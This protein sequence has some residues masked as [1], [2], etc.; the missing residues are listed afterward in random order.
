MATMSTV[1]WHNSHDH[2]N[3]PAAAATAAVRSAGIQQPEKSPIMPS[4]SGSTCPPSNFPDKFQDF[5]AV[6][7]EDVDDLPSML[8]DK[9][10]PR[11]GVYSGLESF[12]NNN[13][14]ISA[15]NNKQRWVKRAF[16]RRS[17]EVEVRLHAMAYSEN[18]NFSGA[19]GLEGPKLPA[20]S[21]RRSSSIAVARPTPD[22]HRF[23]QAEAGPWGHLSPSPRSPTRTPAFSPGATS[24][25]S[26][27][28]SPGTSSGGPSPTSPAAPSAASASTSRLPLQ[29]RQRGRTSSMP[30]V[31][32]HKIPWKM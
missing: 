22:L 8:E 19:G 31:P 14:N 1:S 24:T 23:L 17:S 4:S 20:P 13:N 7:N 25:T 15:S 28:L 29:P 6:L 12:G 18:P 10:I 2:S 16:Q 32:R 27:H 9:L 5:F 26:Q 11:K 3:A 21:R 30:A